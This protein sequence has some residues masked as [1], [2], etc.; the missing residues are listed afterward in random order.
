M[1]PVRFQLRLTHKVAAIGCVGVIG[2]AAVGVIYQ[3]GTWSQDDARKVAEDAR[4]ISGLTKRISIEMLEARR[5][6]KNFL[7]RKQDSYVKHHAQLSGAIGRDF[8]ELKALVR[9]AGYAELSEKIGV[10]HD[11]FESYGNDFAVLALVQAKI[12]LNETAGLTGSLRKAV[13]IVEA[14]VNRVNDPKLTSRLL[15]MRRHE[16]DFMLW[17][18]DKYADEFKK[19]V[20]AFSLVLMEMDLPYD[21][22]EKISLNLNRYSRDFADWVGGARDVARAEADMMKTFGGFEP[23]LVEALKEIDRLAGAAE[24]SEMALRDAMKMRMARRAGAGGAD[25]V[26]VVI[27]A[28]PGDLAADFGDDLGADQTCRR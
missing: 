18:E 26:R 5:D 15:T 17:R 11:G 25:D 8:D 12:G 14:G 24:A 4:A 7:L 20:V 27:A 21:V 16:K 13:E 1:W 9:T 22:Q 3:Q 23:L 2:L 28:R 19:A 6:E 10:I